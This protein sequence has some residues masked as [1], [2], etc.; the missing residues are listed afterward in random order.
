MQMRL[1]SPPTVLLTGGRAPVTL[2]LA[3]AFKH[4]G[5]RVVVI[6][7]FSSALTRWSNCVDAYVTVPAPAQ[8]L[9]NFTSA[10]LK[11]IHEH[12]VDWVVPTC[13]E[14]FYVGM[15][16][17][18]LPCRVW[19]M[20]IDT[21]RL[22]HDKQSFANIIRP[23]MPTPQTQNVS[24][25]TDWENSA[26]YVFKPRFSRFA[27]RTVIGR[28]VQTSDF[29]HPE[30]WIAQRRIIGPE[31]CVYTVWNNGTMKANAMYH[32]TL[33]AGKGA[34]IFLESVDHPGI[35]SMLQHFGEHLALDGQYSFDVI[36]E[37]D[38][39]TPYVIEC[40]PR[41]TSGAHMLGSAAAAAFLDVEATA[42]PETST[43]RAL[44]YAIAMYHPSAILQ[45]KY[46]GTSDVVFRV[47]DPLP[48]LF[49]VLSLLHFG[50]TAWRN[51]CSLL[52]ATTLD[53]E[54]NG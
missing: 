18:L 20:D 9:D 21:L 31:Y 10:L 47:A 19:T 52:E 27:A 22:L 8:H 51:K 54:W 49:Q 50:I 12:N 14:T 43:R 41:A 33:R 40:N 34:G 28:S 36:I 38:S 44:W 6:D 30:Q 24:E 45:R 3:R 39:G 5:C 15:I 23:F 53:I 17:E 13:E 4:Y 1:T 32:P 35:A 16:R 25:F 7:T 48:A 26:E 29:S 11:I 2:E 42:P 37:A 46:R